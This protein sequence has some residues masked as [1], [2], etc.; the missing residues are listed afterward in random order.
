MS[1]ILKDHIRKFIEINDED[2]SSV[3]MFFK[4]STP[5]KKENLLIEGK[6]CKS[7]YFVS[8]GCLRMFFINEKGVEKT[9]QFALEHWWLADYFS[10]QNQIASSFY[11]Q[12]VERSEVWSI[13]LPEHENMLRQF[14]QMER[15][16]R[17]VHQTTNAATQVRIRYL[18]DFSREE[19]Y[20]YFLANFPEFIHRVPQYLLASYL[21][22]TP[23][24]L[25][26]LRAKIIS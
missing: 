3:L 19:N 8:S 17:L 4:V 18:Y 1:Q 14:P 15:Y 12:A 10:F 9:T 26:E 11:I 6:I 5:R 13:D 20:R 25:S 23:E 7:N 24:Y 21:G 22:M 16:F 2:L